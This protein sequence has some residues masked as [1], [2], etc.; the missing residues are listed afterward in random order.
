MLLV[1]DIKVALDNPLDRLDKTTARRIGIDPAA[2]NKLVIHGRSLDCRHTGVSWRYSMLI[3][4]DPE[5]KADLLKA[6]GAPP[7]GGG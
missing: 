4:V 7:G 6:D 3:E 2:I 1:Q 5:V